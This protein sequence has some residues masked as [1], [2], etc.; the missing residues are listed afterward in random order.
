MVEFN[1][2]SIINRVVCRRLSPRSVMVYMGITPGG[3]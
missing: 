3:G 1:Y 2:T